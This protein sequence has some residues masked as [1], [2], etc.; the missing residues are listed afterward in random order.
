MDNDLDM[1]EENTSKY[2]T[3]FPG[4]ETHVYKSAFSSDLKAPEQLPTPP[5]HNYS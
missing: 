4:Y 2:Q 5:C 1:Q 3:M